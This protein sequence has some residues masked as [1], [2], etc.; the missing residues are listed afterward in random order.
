MENKKRQIRE[1]QMD[2]EKAVQEKEAQ[3]E[4][5][6]L[7]SSIALEDERKKLVT[8]AAENAKAESDTRAYSIST[9]MQALSSADASVLQALATSGMRPQQLIAFAFQEL[10][11]KAE[12]IGNL[13]ISPEL[14]SELLANPGGKK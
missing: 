4:R 3:L 2:A 1:T 13:N 7:E 6:K 14:L 5:A 8:L 10:A 9:T 11:A 12:K